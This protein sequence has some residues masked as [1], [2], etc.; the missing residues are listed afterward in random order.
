[1]DKE[2]IMLALDRPAWLGR[3]AEAL[4]TGI[5]WVYEAL[6][7][8]KQP[9]MDALHGKWLR[10]PLHPV[11][12]DVTLGMWMAT[13][14]FD[15]VGLLTGEERTA[16]ACAQTTITAG[17][18]SSVATAAAGATDW[19]HLQGHEQRVGLTHALLNVSSVVFYAGSLSARR[20]GQYETGRMLGLGGLF[21]ASMAAYLGSEMAYPLK[22]GVKHSPNALGTEEWRRV[23]A[24]DDLPENEPRRAEIEGVALALVRQGGQVYA[25]A[26][27]CSH[28][29]GPLDEGRVEGH[30]LTCPWHGSQFDLDTG[31]PVRGPTVYAQ[32]VL[33]VRVRDGQIEVRGP[34]R[35]AEVR[36]APRMREIEMGR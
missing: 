3:W 5:N 9:T 23:A 27:D 11:L 19:M 6:N 25:H 22:V 17:L 33:E 13:G 35:G 8:A 34:K 14:V 15:T 30:C 36:P 31:E 21:I 24:L 20:R 29:G 28:L 2:T 1:M 4:N 7:G 26:A 12:T 18:A 10:H 16:D 32:P